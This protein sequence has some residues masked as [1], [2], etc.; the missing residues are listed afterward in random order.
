MNKRKKRKL[1]KENKLERM[2]LKTYYD[3]LNPGSYGGLI[4]KVTQSHRC[5]CQKTQEY[6]AEEFNLL[7]A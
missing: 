7:F 6:H 4:G 5:T 2:V 3:F 1:D